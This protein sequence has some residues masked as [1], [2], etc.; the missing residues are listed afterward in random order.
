MQYC[1]KRPGNAASPALDEVLARLEEKFKEA[2][3]ERLEAPSR[4]A[5]LLALPPSQRELAARTRAAFRT[6]AVVELLIAPAAPS[7]STSSFDL[8]RL[9]VAVADRL[10]SARYSPSLVFDL[11]ARAWAR[12]AEARRLT[13]DLRG[14]AQALDTAERLLEDGSAD[15]LEEA[16]LLEARAAVVGDRG[17]VETAAVLLEM[18]AEIYES[19]ADGDHAA[20][21]RAAAAEAEA[22]PARA[23]AAG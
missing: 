15:P 8:A 3:G 23:K 4:L 5:E 14:A 20:R 19:V 1:K 9:A 16:H 18:A 6:P 13:G 21:A 22:A 7:S 2:V 12:L 10:D 11:R 17:D